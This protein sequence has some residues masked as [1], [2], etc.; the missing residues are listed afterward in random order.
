LN[1][2]RE[3]IKA[4]RD[5]GVSRALAGNARLAGEG[6]TAA[7]LV[8]FMANR[9]RRLTRAVS[10]EDLAA[11]QEL[12]QALRAFQKAAGPIRTGPGAAG[13]W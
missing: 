10:D 3:G 11:Y 1:I 7:D 12:S 4:L 5:P 13:P 2:P 9:R 8:R 6:K